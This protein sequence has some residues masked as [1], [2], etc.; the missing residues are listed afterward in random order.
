ML[1]F[2][3]TGFTANTQAWI[4]ELFIRDDEHDQQH[5]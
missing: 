4:N 3:T 5:G 2:L 1:K